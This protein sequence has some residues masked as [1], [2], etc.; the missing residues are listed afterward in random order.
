[1]ALRY[2]CSLPNPGTA[3][4]PHE[5][6]YSDDE[7]GRKRAAIFAQREN[8]PGRG[9]YD[10]IAVLKDGA[11]SRNKAEVAELDCVVSDLD[12]KNIAQSRDEVLQCLREL[13]LPPS[14]IRDSGFGLHGVW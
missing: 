9:V 14:E 7:D 5:L 8:R 3:G 13:L 12:L 2:I 10:C 11:K 6:F 4:A 1:M